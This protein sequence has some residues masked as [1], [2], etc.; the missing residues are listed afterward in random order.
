[1]NTKNQ[2]AY[3]LFVSM[4]YLLCYLCLSIPMYGYNL[5]SN[6]GIVQNV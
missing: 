2:C 6:G 3:F 1:M 4:L 5:Y